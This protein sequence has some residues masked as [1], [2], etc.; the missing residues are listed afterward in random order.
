MTG[1]ARSAPVEGKVVM[2]RT[3]AAGEVILPGARGAECLPVA[4]IKNSSISGVLPGFAL[5]ENDRALPILLF[6]AYAA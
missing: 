6:Y 1:P 5:L 2:R 3:N 4:G